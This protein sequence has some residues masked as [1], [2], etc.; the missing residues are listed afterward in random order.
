M[1]QIRGIK[2][3]KL[4]EMLEEPDI[5]DGSEVLLEIQASDAAN[6]P[7]FWQA[8]QQFRQELAS[9]KIELDPQEIFGD[10]RDRR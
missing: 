2:R 1:M 5:L 9:E 10:V 7:D 8:L 4:I 6:L 3:G